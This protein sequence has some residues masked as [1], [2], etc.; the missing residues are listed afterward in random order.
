MLRQGVR[1][2]HEILPRLPAAHEPISLF[3][4]VGEDVE[5]DAVACYYTTD[6]SEPIGHRG[7]AENGDVVMFTETTPAWDNFTWGYIGQWTATLPGFAGGTRLRYRIGAWAASRGDEIYADY[8]DLKLSIEYAAGSH[9]VLGQ[10]PDP[11][12]RCGNPQ[13]GTVFAL[14]MGQ[15]HAPAWAREAI[16]YHL[17]PDRF[18]PGSGRGWLQ[19]EDLSGFCGGT[20]EGVTEKLDYIAELGANCI[21]ISPPYVT[22]SWHGYDTADYREIEPRLGDKD[23]VRR[24]IGAAHDRGLRVLFDMACN[25]VSNHHPIF[26]AA[27]ADS[28]SPYR[29]WFTFDDSEVGYRGFFGV[30]SMPEID[31]S[32]PDARDWMVENGLYWVRE[33]DIDGYRLDYASGARPDFWSYFVGACKAEKPDTFYM[34]EI[35]DPPDMMQAYVGRLDGLLDFPINHALRQTYAW[36]TW[37]EEDL[38]RFLARHQ[39]Y[40]PADFVTPAF[41]DNH[42]MNRFHFVTGGDR[43]AL[44]AA[45]EAL[46]ALPNPPILLYGT[47]VG[48]SQKQDYTEAKTL[49][50]VREPM[51]WGDQQDKELLEKTR[52]LIHR[53]AS[54]K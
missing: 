21:W 53:R 39:Q 37:T 47:A 4:T 20:L 9:F 13:P 17:M 36:K 2:G 8:P 22:P 6:G 52:E 16:I 24:L 49:D 31:L 14:N 35:T 25:H 41:I 40:M 15:P 51:L 27:Q 34:G 29:D 38:Q 45:L 26:Q 43:A 18:N 50:A 42:D 23:T 46:M 5:T 30:E 3:A 54:K 44:L 10:P 32:R 48:L 1:H 12:V 28:T 7:V 19:T 33:F 11:A